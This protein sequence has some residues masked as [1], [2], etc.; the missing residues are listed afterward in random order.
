VTGVELAP[1]SMTTGAVTELGPA[2]VDPAHLPRNIVLDRVRI[3][4][5]GVCARLNGSFVA[6]VDSVL[7]G[8][9]RGVELP[10]GGGPYRISGDDISSTSGAA[11]AAGGTLRPADL[12]VA[13]CHL[14]RTAASGVDLGVAIFGNIDRVLFACNVID[15]S[16]SAAFYFVDAAGAALGERQVGRGVDGLRNDGAPVRVV[17]QQDLFQ[18]ATGMFRV[19][20][21]MKSSKIDHVTVIN[22]DEQLSAV[23]EVNDSTAPFWVTSSIFSSTQYGIH[24][25]SQGVGTMTID[26][27]LAPGKV[28]GNAFVAQSC[29]VYPAGNV[30][31]DTL[32]SLGLESR[33]DPRLRSDSALAGTGADGSDPGAD[34]A[35][36]DQLTKGVAP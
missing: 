33:N 22:W 8:C 13:K 19:D 10:A 11:I 18:D 14:A 25:T 3:S 29:S 36:I 23:L 12:E 6:V 31:P 32:Q 5:G 26:A 9:G 17:I 24:G 1:G 2:D 28:V 21:T 16:S 35:R 4:G 27:D 7:E 15:P 34:V 20:G 30:C